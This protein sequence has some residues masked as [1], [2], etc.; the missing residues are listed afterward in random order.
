MPI[1]VDQVP[2]Y[3]NIAAASHPHQTQAS[4][5]V[6]QARR[7]LQFSGSPDGRQSGQLTPQK[8]ETHCGI[9]RLGG[10]VALGMQGL[11]DS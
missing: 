9:P 5:V 1:A 10:G 2:G 4:W 6:G 8:I 7:A 3:L 11:K